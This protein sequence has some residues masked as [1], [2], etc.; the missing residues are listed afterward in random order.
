MFEVFTFTNFIIEKILFNT[1]LLVYF[2]WRIL[3]LS[4]QG[5]LVHK[6]STMGAWK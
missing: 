2:T 4:I 3:Q 5:I 1:F 6:K